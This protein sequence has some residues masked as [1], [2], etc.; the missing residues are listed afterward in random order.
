MLCP[1]EGGFWGSK[2]L[3]TKFVSFGGEGGA[4]QRDPGIKNWL[5][6]SLLRHL[7]NPTLTWQVYRRPCLSFQ[8]C[9]IITINKTAIKIQKLH[10]KSFAL[11]SKIC[12]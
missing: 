11:K 8:T 1:W 10:S 6:L 5:F 4:T 3:K 9:D 7:I 2:S 12:I